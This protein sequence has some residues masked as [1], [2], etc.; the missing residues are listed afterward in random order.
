MIDWLV[1]YAL[2]K[3]LVASM[4]CVF[5][6]LYGYHAWTHAGYRAR[7]ARP[8]GG[9]AV[10]ITPPSTVAVLRAGYPVQLDAAA[11]SPTG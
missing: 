9:S 1:G 8:R 10:L 2:N 4:I 5:A 11:A 7:R 3:R 6:A